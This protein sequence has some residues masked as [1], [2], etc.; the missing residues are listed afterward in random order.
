[1]LFRSALVDGLRVT[2]GFFPTL[3]V[4]PALGKTFTSNDDEPGSD[5][6]V[7]LSDELWRQKFSADRNILGRTIDLSGEAY[8]VIGVMQFPP[9]E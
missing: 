2:W 8:T 5:H 6:K 4:P 1:M 9:R 3:G 7:I